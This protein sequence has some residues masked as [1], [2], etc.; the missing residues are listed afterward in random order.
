MF[1]GCFSKHTDNRPVYSQ[2]NRGFYDHFAAHSRVFFAQKI[3]EFLRELRNA[4]RCFGVKNRGMSDRRNDRGEIAIQRSVLI[5]GI[6]AGFGKGARCVHADR[7]KRLIGGLDVATQL[8]L[9]Q[10][11]QTQNEQSEERVKR[12]F[13]VVVFAIR[14]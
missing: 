13:L 12:G 2:D 9:I 4:T 6:M 1:I 5:A 11:K 10:A 7:K 14:G 8:A 3:D